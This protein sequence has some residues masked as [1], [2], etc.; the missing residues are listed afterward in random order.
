MFRLPVINAVGIYRLT[1]QHTE[2]G[3]QIASKRM[4]VSVFDECRCKRE[5][6]AFVRKRRAKPIRTKHNMDVA[7]VPVI[8]H[9]AIL[10]E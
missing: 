5:A 10:F 9:W 2:P 3:K 7:S 1:S 4:T 8:P 6:R